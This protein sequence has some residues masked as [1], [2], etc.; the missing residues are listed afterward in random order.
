MNQRGSPVHGPD[1]DPTGVVLA[2]PAKL[3]IHSAAALG[4]G[5]LGRPVMTQPRAHVLLH[6]V[7]A[8]RQDVPVPRLQ[9]RIVERVSVIRGAVSGHR[10]LSAVNPVVGRG[11]ARHVPGPGSYAVAGST[12]RVEADVAA[13]VGAQAASAASGAQRA[14]QRLATP[15]RNRRKPVAEALP[16]AV[17]VLR[18]RGRGVGPEPGEVLAIPRAEPLPVSPG[19][20]SVVMCSSPG[21]SAADA[22]GTFRRKRLRGI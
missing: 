16:L 2:N 4:V 3:V 21:S 22:T 6:R 14:S 9:R 5:Q 10:K 19:A 15:R 12:L 18:Q 7:V 8:Y 11:I 20:P 17:R 1:A 13:G